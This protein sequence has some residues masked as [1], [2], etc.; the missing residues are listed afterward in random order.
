MSGMIRHPSQQPGALGVESL[1]A[2]ATFVRVVDDGSFSSAGRSLG[3]SASGVGKTI[4]RL[5]AKLGA[6][7]FN[8]STR[9]L[10]L[11]AEGSLL[12]ERCR[13]ILGEIEAI[14]AEITDSTGRPTGRLRLGLP[15]VGEP[16][17]SILSGFARA[18]PQIELDLTLDDRRADLIQE[19]YDIVLRTGDVGVSALTTRSLGRFTLLLAAAPSYISA[20]G[21]PQTVE[22]LT[23]HRCITFRYA[24][25]G[26]VHPWPQIEELSR[27]SEEGLIISNNVEARI[28]FTLQGLGI[29]LLPNFG[30]HEMLAEGRLVHVLPQIS[31]EI[32]VHLLWPSGRFPPPK[33]RALIDYLAA[34]LAPA[35]AAPASATAGVHP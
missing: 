15:I 24:H 31:E 13:R 34:K 30:I 17:L 18:F 9:S 14:G 23:R 32:P 22:E 4:S 11:T 28:A 19:G 21:M 12:L 8:R 7:L 6:R 29:G 33:V 3:I 16:F 10:V 27:D 5:E 26:K 25:S 20:N 35:L 2:L 1:T